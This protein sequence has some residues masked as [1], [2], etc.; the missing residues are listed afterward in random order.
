MA[1]N[2]TALYSSQ[3]PGGVFSIES[4]D[5]STGSRFY[6]DS[7]TGSSTFDGQS[8]NT[9]KATVAQAIALCTADKG[10]II[11]VMP[12]HAESFAA[13][14]G[15]D[16]TKAGVTI[17]G[18]GWGDFRPTFT[19]TDT[20]GTIAVGAASVWVDT[21]RF[22]AG[23]SAVVVGVNVEAAGV[24]CRITNCQWYWGG[25][26]GFDFLQALNINVGAHRALVENCQ[27]IAEP[28]VAGASTAIE[29]VGA[30]HN[31]TVRNCEFSGDYS[32]ACMSVITTLCQHL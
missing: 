29:L 18:L 3:N 14:D 21:L 24:A 12:K 13:A 32:L 26:T 10:D 11:Y 2:K 25:T 27:F 30:V 7:V 15:F 1:G 23:I 16:V 22:V 19:F 8:P 28:A 5:I 20:D 17:R 6:V 9:P 4:Q 31:V